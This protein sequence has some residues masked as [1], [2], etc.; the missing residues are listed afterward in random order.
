MDKSAFESELKSGGWAEPVS[1]ERPGGDFTGDHQHQFHA[2][3]LITAGQITIEVAG[4]PTTYR[5]G[6]IFD[7]APGTPHVENVGPEG[8]TYYVGR[9]MA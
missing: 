2:R 1:I 4:N 6:D 3:A 5:V 8:V 9:R 7:L